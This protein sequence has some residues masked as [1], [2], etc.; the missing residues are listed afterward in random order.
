[1]SIDSVVPA[2]YELIRKNARFDHV[3]A[4]VEYLLDYTRRRRAVLTFAVCPMT[5]NWREL[6]ALVD[7]CA[8]RRIEV[9]FNTVTFPLESCL[10][11][12]S[13]NDLGK[14]STTSNKEAPAPQNRGEA[15]LAPNG[16]AF[17]I[18]CEGG[19]RKSVGLRCR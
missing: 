12:L 16:M 17:S 4:N 1:M 3:M 9:Y 13:E 6:P 5:H 8:E 11:S 14:S 15:V 19:W 10:G 18:N 7:F 2:T